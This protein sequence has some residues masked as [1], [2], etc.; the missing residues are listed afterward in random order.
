MFNGLY[1]HTNALFSPFFKRLSGWLFVW[2]AFKFV[3]LDAVEFL[4]AFATV[5]TR[6]V[7]VGF[8]RVF[9]HVPVEWRSLSTLIPTYLTSVGTG[10]RKTLLLWVSTL[11]HEVTFIKYGRRVNESHCNGV[12]PVCVRLCTSKWFLRLN[13]LPQV[14]HIKSRTP[15]WKKVNVCFWLL[16][17]IS[18]L[19][20]A[21]I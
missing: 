11:H 19:R 17:N 8:G 3:E 4:E 14:S 12:S 7:E 9:P 1:K 15:A 18:W 6:V 10:S 21:S 16:I 20:K 13:D 5:L 2:M